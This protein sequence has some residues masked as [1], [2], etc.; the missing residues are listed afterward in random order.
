MG[1]QHK[2]VVNTE[3]Q[4]RTV[5]PGDIREN[6]SS[7]DKDPLL[8]SGNNETPPETEDPDGGNEVETPHRIEGDDAGSIER[9]I[10][11]M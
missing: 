8:K 9:K 4:N 2:K 10:P 5:N 11:N 6:E 3:E 1:S 7:N